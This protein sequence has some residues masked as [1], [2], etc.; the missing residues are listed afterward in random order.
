[1]TPPLR[2]VLVDIDGTLIDSNEA[3]TRAW[4]EVLARRHHERPYEAIRPLI[5]KGGDKL[6]ADVVGTDSDAID[7]NALGNERAELFLS[8]ELH[9]LKPTRGARALLQKLHDAGL[10]VV[11]A[12]SAK[13]EET[14]ALLRQ[15][16]LEDLIDRAANA[17]DADESKPAPDIIQSALRK[18]G[19]RPS[20]A[21]MLG[22]TPHDIEAARKAGV[23]TVILR[24][25]GW[26]N[27]DAFAG[28]AA[29][30]DDPAD[31]LKA[32]DDSPLSPVART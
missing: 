5:G 2:T 10:Q 22:D 9:Q 26:W 25:G 11:V 21:V 28:A 3:H 24:C 20:E 29:I 12:T 19:T 31:L 15:A 8:C 16:G 14:Q 13:A 7:A 17:D 30:Y 32:F 18:S 6:L 1:M 27:D 23:A 4:L